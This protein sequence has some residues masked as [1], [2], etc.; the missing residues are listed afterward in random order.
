MDKK[1]PKNWVEVTFGEVAKYQNGKAFKSSEW[2]EEGLPIIRIQNLSKKS[3]RFNRTTVKH[4]DKYFIE[5]GD[6]LFAWSATLLAHFWN[7][8]DAWL[9]QHIFR[10]DNYDSV[11]NKKYLYFLLQD[12]IDELMKQTHGMG[13]VHITKRKFEINKLPLP[14]LAEQKRIVAKLDELFGHLDS[15]KTRLHHI[16]QILKNFRQA[17][18]T[19]AVTG[20]L[21]EEWRVGK[22]LEKFDYVAIHNKRNE[23]YELL[24]KEN[25]KK[26]IKSPNKPEYLNHKINSV[27][28]FSIASWLSAP[29]GFLCD[30]IVPGRDKPKSFTGDMPWITTPDL[31]SDFI[32]SNNARLYLSKAEVLEVRAKVIPEDSV[33]ISIVGRFGVAC[34]IKD[35]CVINQQLHAFLPSEYVL[36]EYLMYYFKTQEDVMNSISTSTTIAYINKTKANSIMVNVPPKEEQTEIV[37]RVEHLFA[38]ADTIEAQYQSL[39]TKIDSLPQAILA[40]AFKGEL[41]EQ[42]DTDGSAEDLLEE[43]QKIKASLSRKPSLRGTK[44][45]AKGKKIK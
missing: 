26:G 27:Q 25:K 5:D 33:V 30:C 10:V 37:K 12:K 31:K 43:I 13:M 21:T 20:K 4:E 42:L 15:L 39:K 45:S 7:R 6:L 17:V 29:V 19:Q 3:A 8:G 28:N 36:P 24:K 22:E 16:P 18:L 35:A 38:K 44:Q 34:V 40:K 32:Y 1:L 11:I 14:P 2:E 41:V 23:Q 9:N